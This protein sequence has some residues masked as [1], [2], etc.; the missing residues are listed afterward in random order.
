M[1]VS[2]IS[3]FAN[4]DPGATYAVKVWTGDAAGTEV[5]S[6]DVAVFTVD[7]FNIIDLDNPVT[8]DA[9]MQYWIGYEVTHGAGTFPAGADD[10]PAVQESGDMISLDG[11]DWV[12]MS[13]AYGLDYNWN[14]QAYVGLGDKAATSMS[15]PANKIA[16]S[17]NVASAKQNGVASGVKNS[18]APVST[19]ELTGYDVY[20]DGS[21]IGNT[22][23]TAYTDNISI[24]GTYTYCVK[25][26][27]DNGVSDCSNDHVVDVLVGINEVLFSN[28]QVYPNP[29]S[30]VVNVKSEMEI[31]NVK[32]YNNTGQL[33]SDEQVNSKL[34][35]LNTS[36]FEAGLYFFQIESNDAVIS[37]RIIIK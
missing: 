15:K 16:S 31:T 29:A 1:N 2:Q 33:V 30:D 37:K 35:Q 13:A 12:G 25:A 22:T 11:V 7:D 18:F 34:Y 4:G 28:T 36:Q 5:M 27:Y 3:F 23:E 20:R 6:Q 19:K 14:I 32:V 17:G 8:I 26:I 9:S 21:V 24:S 10:G